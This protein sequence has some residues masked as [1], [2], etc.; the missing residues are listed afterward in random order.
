MLLV[1]QSV[2]AAIAGLDFDYAA[3]ATTAPVGLFVSVKVHL[4][5]LVVVSG[6]PVNVSARLVELQAVSG[7]IL[8][9]ALE[10][11][12]AVPEFLSAAFFV[13]LAFLK[14]AAVVPP[15]AVSDWLILQSVLIFAGFHYNLS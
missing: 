3:A 15:S 4:V 10:D 8:A 9:V 2:D 12:F 13:L 14:A 1:E 7:K 6:C 5:A 11:A